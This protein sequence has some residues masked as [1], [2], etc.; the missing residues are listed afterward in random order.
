MDRKYFFSLLGISSVSF[1]FKKVMATG[2]AEPQK[3]Y[4]KDDGKIPNSK[5][6]LLVYRNALR[7]GI[8]AAK[9]KKQFAANNWTN[10]WENGVY[11]FHHYHSTSHEV[12]GIY[13]GSAKL[14]FG[15]EN[16]EKLKVK[17]GDIVIIPA[18]VG[19][20]NLGATSDFGVVGAYPE[21]RDWDLLKGEPGERP[22]ADKNIA[23]LPVPET[24]PLL[25]RSEGLRKIWA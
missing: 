18:G 6:P 8:T 19:H 4:F 2:A 11:S 1:L 23:A 13:S 5:L 24:D 15:G 22:T 20:K 17:A 25:G 16:G 21:G 12:L 3:F 10:S 7:S 14:H 9:L